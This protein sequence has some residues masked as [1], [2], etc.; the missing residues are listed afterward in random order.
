MPRV[1]CGW[2]Q[3]DRVRSRPVG[4]RRSPRPA[5]ARGRTRPIGTH[6]FF[7]TNVD[8]PDALL[9]EF[10]QALATAAEV[11]DRAGFVPRVLDL[12]GGF[13]APSARP[14]QLARHPL[15][16]AGIHRAL[17][18][19]FPGRDAP[20]LLFESGRYLVAT[21]G[22][23]LT[24]V[25]DV[26]RSGDRTFVVV[27]A[28]INVLGGMSGLGRLLAP[29]AQPYGTGEGDPS[30]LAGPLCTPLDVLST[31][32]RLPDPRPGQL[33]A[34][35]NVG[36]YGLTASLLGF[37]SRPPTTEIVTDRGQVLSARRLSVQAQEV[38]CDV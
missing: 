15:L 33:L 23:L 35:P 32:V 9:Q 6:T 38:H 28:G 30:V 37:L 12:G 7:A 26:K 5:A 18:A 8:Q 25:L 16:S 20:D 34:I 2:G 27:D 3:T 1:P 22:T 17:D 24:T 21:A 19:R 31:S 29:S 11:V 13:P 10:E 36:A 14:G 4:R